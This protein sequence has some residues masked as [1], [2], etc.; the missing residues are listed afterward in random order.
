[1]LNVIRYQWHH[2]IIHS[3]LYTKLINLGLN[4]LQEWASTMTNKKKS[5]G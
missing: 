2:L 4:A 1:M 3:Q 5:K